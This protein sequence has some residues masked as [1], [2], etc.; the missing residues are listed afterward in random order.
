[1][2]SSRDNETLTRVGP[3]TAMGEVM[4]RYWHPICTSEQVAKPDSDPVRSRLLGEDFVVF[5]DTNGKVGVLE[6]F[7]MHRRVSLAL[8]RVEK[9]GIRCLYH[10]WKFAA[11]GTI[12]ETPNHCDA[13]LRERRKAPA[14]PA[15]EAGG[16]VWTYIG[17]QE[18]RPPLPIWRFMQPG[19]EENRVVVRL[20][21]A[22]NY[23][24]LWEGGAD[25]SH[26][27]ILH[28]NMANPSWI[29][30]TFTPAQDDF[31]PGALTVDD[32]SPILDVHDTEFGFHCAA[33]RKLPVGADGIERESLRVVEIMLPT[34]RI[35]PAPA[36]EFFV[37]ETPQDDHVTSTYI[38]VHGDKPI[39]KEA[40][41]QVLGLS[42]ERFWSEK[43]CEFRASWDNKMFQD[44]PGMKENWTGFSGIEQE[45]AV[46]AV[47]MGPII[48]R[49]KELLVA[50]DRAVVHLRARLL[51]NVGL[52]QAGKNPIGVGYEDCTRVRALAD[53][54][55]EPGQDWRGCVAGSTV[56]LPDPTRTAAE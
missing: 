2:M 7:C 19:P 25:S 4:R 32:N 34:A 36:Y 1:M 9:G 46:M 38:V 28:S 15:V 45:D 24:Q 16:L 37:F 29:D 6:E 27:G 22:A 17:D 42:D 43:D 48:D 51:E 54:V 11:D 49:S 18:K 52:V 44:R 30:E 50:A 13:R 14:Y 5:R 10:G 3:G 56:S 33:K 40:I 31:N 35:V 12:L 23:L 55:L 53:T 26:V 41:F 21:T 8:G 39:S 20:N 47:S